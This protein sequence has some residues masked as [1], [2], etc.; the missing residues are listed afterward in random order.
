MAKKTISVCIIEDHALVRSGLRML[1]ENHAGM[2]VVGE[3]SNRAEAF[4]VGKANPPDIFILDLDLKHENGL[5]FLPELISTFKSSRVLVVTASTDAEAHQRAI[6]AGGLGLVL[7]E[8]ASE[9]LLT[10]IGKLHAGEAWLSPALTAAVLSKI[11][12]SPDD[13]EERKIASLTKREREII[14]LIAQGFKRTQ[15]A[16]KLFISE[17]TVRNHLTSIL[18]KLKLSDRFELVFYAFRHGLAKP[19]REMQKDV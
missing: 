9:V 7:K 17:T 2:R 11:P 19:P 3:A 6:K 15:I 16:E 14:L 5:D 12:G 4:K 1:I 10:A 18:Y 8:Q 13:S